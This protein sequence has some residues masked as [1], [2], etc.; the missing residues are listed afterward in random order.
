MAAPVA[1]ALKPLDRSHPETF[2]SL[3]KRIKDS[4]TLEFWLSSKAYSDII[5]FLLQL[6]Y[7]MFPKDGSSTPFDSRTVGELSL[8]VRRLQ[9]L[10][11]ILEGIID[12]APPDTGPRRFGNVSFRKWFDIVR[13]RLPDLLRIHLPKECLQFPLSGLGLPA[14][15]ELEEYLLGSF[16]SAQRLDYG[17]GHELSFLAFLGGILKL[18][19]FHAD[20]SGNEERGIVLGIIEPWAHRLRHGHYLT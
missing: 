12:E 9:E 3:E 7:A 20:G 2:T 15:A 11:R 19:G 13:S 1:P 6:N 8:P 4:D 10:L 18:G 14:T 17:T 5:T 16:G